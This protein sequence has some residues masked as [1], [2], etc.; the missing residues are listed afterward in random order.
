M[1]KENSHKNALNVTFYKRTSQSR[2]PLAVQATTTFLSWS[3]SVSSHGFERRKEAPKGE[4]GSFHTEPGQ[5]FWSGSVPTISAFIPQIAAHYPPGSAAAQ[6][7]WLCDKREEKIFIFSKR[8][9]RFF[10]TL[11]YERSG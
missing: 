5:L 7:S 6:I 3:H 10:I 11:T 9:K 1:Y 2:P 4:C 8:M